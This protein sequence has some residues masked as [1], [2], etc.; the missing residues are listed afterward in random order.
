[1]TS[2]HGGAF[3]EQIGPDFRHLERRFDV[4]NADV[5]DAW[6]PPAPSVL[7]SLSEGADWGCRTSPPNHS[8]GLIE[9]LANHLHLHPDHFLV[10][11]GSSSLMFQAFR[12]WIGPSSRVLLV[13]PTYGEYAH[14]AELCGA[15]V[16]T[17]SLPFPFRVDLDEWVEKVEKGDYDLVVLV[18]PNNPTGQAFTARELDA[19]L[20][21]IPLKTRVW[22]DEAYAAYVPGTSLCTLRPNVFVLRS[23]SKAYALSG[24]RVAYLVG[25]KDAIRDLRRWSPPWAVSFPAQRAAI[26]ALSETAYYE[27][28]YRQTDRLRQEFQE[29]LSGFP[30]VQGAANWLLLRLPEGRSATALTDD[31]SRRGVFVR[32][33]GKTAPVLGDGYLR[34]AVKPPP[35]LGRLVDEINRALSA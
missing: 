10:G 4:I 23:M 24:L 30:W 2:Y 9:S 28:R 3:W 18:N 14:L 13:D 1:M 8:E 31:L 20:D 17:L 33:A 15:L 12:Q 25:P 11:P 27:D 26:L 35:E 19:V 5:L 32:N 22:I 21:R 29:G 6:F 34:V 16:D 7:A